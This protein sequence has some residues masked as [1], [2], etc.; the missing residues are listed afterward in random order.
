M[1]DKCVSD[2]YVYKDGNVIDNSLLRED[3]DWSTRLGI[4]LHP[5][6]TINNITY[7]GDVNGYDVFRAICAGFQDLPNVCK[8]D[9]VFDVVDL[10]D[11]FTYRLKRKNLA[12]VYHIIGAV[13]LV[14]SLNLFALCLYRRYARKKLNEELSTQVNSAVSQYFKLSGQDTSRE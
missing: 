2:S 14:L 11:Q 13:I 6:V 12:K 5:G 4:I 3:R 10:Q 9:N 1:V 8:G 7:R